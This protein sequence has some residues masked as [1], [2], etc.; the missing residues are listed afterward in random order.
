MNSALP[1]RLDGKFVLI[2][3]AASG[4]GAAIASRCADEGARV[5]CSD[6]DT[7]STKALAASLG[8]NALAVD[9]DVTD[10]DS[11]QD[12]VDATA[13][14]FGRLD[15]L[16]HNAAAPSTDGT[17]ADL[18]VDKWRL[19]LDVSLTGAFLISKFA[20]PLMASS[21]GGSIVFIGSQFARVAVGKA[22]AYCAAKAGLVHL[23]KAMAI[24]HA[25]QNI[26][27]NSLSPGAVATARLLQRWS[28]LEAAD[29]GLGPAHLLGR[30]AEPE[31]IAAACA[32]LL[33]SD[34]SFV[35]G[36]DLLVDG[37]YAVR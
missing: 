23:A 7:A 5:A 31:E 17:V 32:F 34:A 37:G 24:D 27:V 20:V 35:T 3:G 36:T 10:P 6:R 2:T 28:S 18:S 1:H 33:S 29:K 25:D 26:R 13:Q 22:V 15:G 12:A 11:V 9:C 4:I 21:G 16:V 30:I 8:P 19:E 14:A